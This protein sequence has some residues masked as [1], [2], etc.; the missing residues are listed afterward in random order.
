VLLTSVC[1]II[2]VIV[3]IIYYYGII[4]SVVKISRFKSCEKSKRKI[5][6]WLK[7]ALKEALRRQAASWDPMTLSLSTVLDRSSQHSNQTLSNIG[8]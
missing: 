5:A 3:I 6:K 2:I 8:P 4:P 1:I 7:S